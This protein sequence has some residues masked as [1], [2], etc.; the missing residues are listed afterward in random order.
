MS[1]GRRAYMGQRIGC[2]ALAIAATGK[3][4]LAQRGHLG[5]VQLA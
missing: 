1:L 2:I 5:R 4:T 3:A